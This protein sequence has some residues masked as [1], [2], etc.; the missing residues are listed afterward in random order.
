MP[1]IINEAELERLA[2]TQNAQEAQD[3]QAYYQQQAALT[4]PAGVG[5]GALPISAIQVGNGFFDTKNALDYGNRPRSIEP[6]INT[7][8]GEAGVADGPIG[9]VELERLLAEEAAAEGTAGGNVDDQ[10]KYKGGELPRGIS[11]HI[12]ATLGATVTPGGTTRTVDTRD[13]ADRAGVNNIA[14]VADDRD[15][16]A[17]IEGLDDNTKNELEGITAQAN[18]LLTSKG[19]SDSGDWGYARTRNMLTGGGLG[20][21]VTEGAMVPWKSQGQDASSADY[22]SNVGGQDMFPSRLSEADRLKS[23]GSGDLV[24]VPEGQ[25][26]DY[27][28]QNY[29]TSGGGEGHTPFNEFLSS[30]DNVDS[31]A[32]NTAI[33]NFNRL[34]THEFTANTFTGVD[35]AKGFVETILSP[36]KGGINAVEN[37]VENVLTFITDGLGISDSDVKDPGFFKWLNTP[38]A[39]VSTSEIGIKPIDIIMIAAGGM[40]AL[41]AIAV[42][43]VMGGVLKPITS[44]IKG[45]LKQLFSGDVD[46]LSDADKNDVVNEWERIMDVEVGEEDTNTY[47]PN[48]KLDVL[49]SGDFFMSDPDRAEQ[50][51]ARNWIID[52]FN[53]GNMMNLSGKRVAIFTNNAGNVINTSNLNIREGTADIVPGPNN[54]AWGI[55]GGAAYEIKTFNG[56]NVTMNEWNDGRTND[57]GGGGGGGI[58]KTLWDWVTSK[59]E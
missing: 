16:G 32:L 13:Y 10:D 58:L 59:Q 26:V 22:I 54:T 37:A 27:L 8:G 41:G 25:K 40:P 43:K 7:L 9:E 36:I 31:A 1:P 14:N 49:M 51:Q 23:G 52:S 50:D 18:K 4:Q 30:A 48:N 6:P 53:N 55:S 2:Q 11:P 3:A 28:R 39:A 21:V 24:Y 19:W 12:E 56:S 44:R 45:T 17:I 35:T 15:A 47:D 5:N 42:G 57:T 29:G 46:E 38:L 20:P 34:K 33:T